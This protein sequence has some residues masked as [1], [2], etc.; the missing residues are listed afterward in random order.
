MIFPGCEFILLLHH[1][2]F[3]DNNVHSCTIY[4]EKK[5]EEEDQIKLAGT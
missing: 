4:A 1:C 5:Q 2:S 3:G